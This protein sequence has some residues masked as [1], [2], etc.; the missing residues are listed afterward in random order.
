MSLNFV[1]LHIL[2]GCLKLGKYLLLF[3]PTLP[4]SITLLVQ[5]PKFGLYLIHF[6]GHAFSPDRFFLD[7]KLAD[8]AVKLSNRLRHGVHLKAE[9][10]SRLVNQVNSLVRKETCSN[11]SM[12]ELYRRYQGIILYTN[13]MMVFISLLKSAHDRYRCRR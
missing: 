9:L 5:I 4:Q 10:G 7:L 6:Q 11:V 8:A 1:I 12:R 2:T 3:L 13:L